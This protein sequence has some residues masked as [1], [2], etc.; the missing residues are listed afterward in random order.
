MNCGRLVFG[1][2]PVFSRIKS[3]ITLKA[4]DFADLQALGAL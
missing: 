3:V 2:V 4:G 1:A